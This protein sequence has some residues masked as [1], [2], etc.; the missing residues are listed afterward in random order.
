MLVLVKEDNIPCM[1]WLL[2]RIYQLHPGKDG[3]VKT[4]T[5]KTANRLIKRPMRKDAVLPIHCENDL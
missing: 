3:V 5:L 4:V 1:Q 2:E